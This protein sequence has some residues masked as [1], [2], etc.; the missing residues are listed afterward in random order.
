MLILSHINFLLWARVYY[1][2]E[3]LIFPG[4]F[5]QMK[6]GKLTGGHSSQQPVEDVIVSLAVQLYTQSTSMCLR[7]SN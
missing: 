6:L 4:V 2:G 7:T 3:V 5:G 1:L